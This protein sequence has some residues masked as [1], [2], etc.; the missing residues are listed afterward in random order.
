MSITSIEACLQ[1]GSMLRHI[2][3]SRR[4]WKCL[5][6]LLCELFWTE[7]SFTCK[8]LTKNLRL[9]CPAVDW[10]LANKHT[11]TRWALYYR[12]VFLRLLHII[13]ANTQ[14]QANCY[15]LKALVD[16][17]FSSGGV[18]FGDNW[19]LRS[20]AQWVFCLFS[21][22][23]QLT[24][25]RNGRFTIRRRHSL[26]EIVYGT[27]FQLYLQWLFCH[28]PVEQQRLNSRIYRI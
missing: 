22:R 4:L 14:E 6:T 12:C 19:H 28:S 20:D 9:K 7:S 13:Q 8:Q 18:T 26:K 27:S 11:H 10:L 15:S 23:Q 1:W 17:R 2:I 21:T 16:P 24:A 25:T 3:D 5:F